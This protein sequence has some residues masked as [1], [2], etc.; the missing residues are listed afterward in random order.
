MAKNDKLV[1]ELQNKVKAKREQLAKLDVKHSYLTSASF[2]F[3]DSGSAINL[4]TV[5]DMNVIVDMM[6]AVILKENTSNQ[7]ISELGMEPQEILYMGYPI[8][9]WKADI[10][11]R[12]N[13]LVYLAEKTKFDLLE[14]KLASLESEELKT[15]KELASIMES[16]G[17]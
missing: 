8:K 4:H 15:E 16:L 3:S 17:E 9:D 10:T 1:L 12:K 5:S 14:K 2:R 11:A 6:A 13:K 7:A